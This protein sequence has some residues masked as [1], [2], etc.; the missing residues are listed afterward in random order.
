M[1][2]RRQAGTRHPDSRVTLFN[3]GSAKCAGAATIVAA[4]VRRNDDLWLDIFI[5]TQ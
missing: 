1:G 4:D 2:R 3:H 5:L